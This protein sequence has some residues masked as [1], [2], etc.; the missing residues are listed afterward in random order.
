MPNRAFGLPGLHQGAETNRTTGW[1]AQQFFAALPYST[2]KP[3]TFNWDVANE[4]VLL[5][6]LGQNSTINFP[7]NATR[8]AVYNILI[9]Q[10]GT[11]SRT[12]SYASES[13]SATGRI[14]GQQNATLGTWKWP[15]GT[16]PTLTTTASKIDLLTFIYDGQ[17][18]IGVSQ[19]N[20]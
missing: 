9:K 13:T 18:M 6:T 1:R 8:G 19:L 14:S 11:G 3:A 10:D 20:F 5:V 16:A 17:D 2:T 12:L 15:S 7:I 4:Q